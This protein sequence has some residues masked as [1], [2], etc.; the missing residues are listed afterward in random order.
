MSTGTTDN[1][2]GRTNDPVVAQMRR[3]F[4]EEALKMRAE[5]REEFQRKLVEQ[6]AEYSARIQENQPHHHRDRRG[7]RPNLSQDAIVDAA[8]K[9]MRS[10]GL[11][12]VTMR[13]IAHELNTGPASMYVHVH[14]VVELHGH[15]LDHLY[16]TLDLSG[17][18]GDWRA[19][20]K[21]LI[22]DA[23]AVML[24]YP[25]LA[26]SAVTARPMGHGSLRFAERLLE[27]MN[28]GGI[29]RDR[30]AWGVDLLLL[31]ATSSA[32]EHSIDDD[33]DMLGR[34]RAAI[35]TGSYP[36]MLAAQDVLLSG[37]ETERMGWAIDV[38]LAGIAATEVPA[39][40]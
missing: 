21:H 37:F 27:L 19:R 5:L 6:M 39:G 28:E 38:L 34:L 23:M 7:R 1:A 4:R 2:K 33:A 16:G 9:I 35:G 18:P 10:K 12:K 30:A 36:N 25:E 31:Y 26:R 40:T 20:I 24:E 14:S 29:P 13:S 17:G 8:M 11:D 22:A 3:E 15:M 32:A